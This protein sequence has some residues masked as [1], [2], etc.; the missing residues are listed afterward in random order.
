M[1]GR[2]LAAG[3]APA[4]ATGRG[5]HS[6][7]EVLIL[8][9]PP[10]ASIPSP[11][12]ILAHPRLALAGGSGH[13]LPLTHFM[14]EAER[15]DRISLMHEGK[16]LA[17][18]APAD[19]R[20]AHSGASLEDVFIGVLEQAQP[21]L[22][23]EPQEATRRRACGPPP[24]CANG[25]ISAASGPMRGA[26]CWRS[27]AIPPASPSRCWGRPCCSSP[28]ATASPSMWRTSPSPC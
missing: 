12:T 26:R 2:A 25:S 14:N 23:P 24:P 16:V 27:A 3:H 19:M 13:D 10:P 1:R 7:P 15:C 21:A 9:E 28:S 8:D 4:P 18:G 20:A 17:V 11:V 5:A 6:P 22:A